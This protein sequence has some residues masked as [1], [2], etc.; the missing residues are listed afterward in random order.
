MLASRYF[1]ASLLLGVSF[2]TQAHQD[3]ALSIEIDNTVAGIPSYFGS[4]T[5]EISG[6]GSNAPSIKF[7]AGGNLTTLQSCAAL[8]IRSSSLVDVLVSG[9]WYH[10][11]GSL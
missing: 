4:V 5:L 6:L 1:S 7:G 11:E 9:S 8:L 2:A 10:D 3:T